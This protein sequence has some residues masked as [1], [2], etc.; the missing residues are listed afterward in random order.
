[1]PERAFQGLVEFLEKK[2]ETTSQ[3]KIARKINL[4]QSQISLYQG[5]APERVRWWRGIIKRIYDL[6]YKDGQREA[7][8]KL[9]GSIV[10]TFGQIPRADLAESLRV[11]RPAVNIDVLI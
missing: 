10:D 11:S 5:K 4:N 8:R 7:N 6:G 1:M 9:M 3:N 2:Y